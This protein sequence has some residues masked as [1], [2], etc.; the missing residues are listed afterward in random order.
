MCKSNCSKNIEIEGVKYNILGFQLRKP[1]M[2]YLKM[3]K[4]ALIRI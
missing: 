1:K 2:L 3:R 4:M